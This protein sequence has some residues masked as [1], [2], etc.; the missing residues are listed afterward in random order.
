MARPSRLR[1]VAGDGPEHAVLADGHAGSAWNAEWARAL[2]D[3][4]NAR[5]QLAITPISRAEVI[6]ALG[7]KG[8]RLQ[9]LDRPVASVKR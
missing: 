5:F 9:K 7:R 3:L 4:M 8:G 6:A 2:V 1:N